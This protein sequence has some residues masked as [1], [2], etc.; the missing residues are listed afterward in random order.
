[1]VAL[2]NGGARGEALANEHRFADVGAV[3]G[4]DVGVED[5]SRV[6]TGAGEERD[7]AGGGVLRACVPF[8]GRSRVQVGLAS[9]WF[10]LEEWRGSR[11]G[12]LVG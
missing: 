6:G 1:V 3:G 4:G 5:V 7:R 8:C 11:E 10:G 2:A 9:A 12:V